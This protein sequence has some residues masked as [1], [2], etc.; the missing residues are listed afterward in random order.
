MDNPQ[1][2]TI[3]D[4]SAIRP[5]PAPVSQN[6][7]QPT[8]QDLLDRLGSVEFSDY[9]AHIVLQVVYE[10][11]AVTAEL[12]FARLPHLFPTIRKCRR[13]LLLMTKAGDV[14]RV[15]QY[16]TRS[17]PNQP[18][19]YLLSSEGAMKLT[20]AK[21]LRYVSHLDWNRHERYAKPSQY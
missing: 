6:V 9:R 8:F 12:V 10:Y 13:C 20:G 17:E 3:F 1:Q 16:R 7:E 4:S 14:L 21:S 19:I 5:V 11:R 15:E 2:F 18:Y